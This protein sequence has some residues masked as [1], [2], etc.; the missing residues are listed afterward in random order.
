MRHS[1]K[2]QLATIAMAAGILSAAD[3]TPDGQPDLQ[4]IWTNATLTPLE[5]PKE[6][7]GKEWPPKA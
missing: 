5:R 2:L 1:T 6:L 4:G 7:A 3:R